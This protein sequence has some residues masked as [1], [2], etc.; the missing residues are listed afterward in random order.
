MHD[1]SAVVDPGAFPWT[2]GQWT[3]RAFAD[4]VI[5]ECHVGT[6]TPDG[7][8]DS[9]ISRLAE[10]RDLGITAVELMPVASFPGR[11]NWGY[12]G[13]SLFAPAEV[14]GGPDSLR[15]FVDASHRLGLAVVLDVVFN[16]F[17]PD[18]NYTGLYSDEYV[19][20]RYHTPWGPAVNFD[21]PG[22]MA[23]RAFF[24]ENLLHW[25]HEYHLDGFRLDA[26]HAIFDA[27]PVHILAELAEAVRDAGRPAPPY[28]IAESHENDVRYVHPLSVGHGFD[29]VWADDFHHAMR[30]L[31]VDEHDG[32]LRGFDG[33]MEALAT[34]IRN[35]FLY[36]GQHDIG[37]GAPRGTPAR[38]VP[39][40]SFVYCIQN[41]D[42]V[43][44]R[45]FGQR[46]NITAAHADFVAATL[47]LLTLPAIPL[48][49]EGQEFA[50]TTPFLYFTD[51]H[52][53]LGRAVSEGRKREFS[54]FHGFTNPLAR[55]AIPDPQA[56]T[57]YSRSVL[58]HDEASYG[59]GLLARQLVKAALH[60]RAQDSV[61]RAY[62][63]QRLPLTTEVT[64]SCVVVAFAAQGSRRW[65]AFNTGDALDVRLDGAAAP[66]IVL[67]SN[68]G[69]FGGND[70]APTLRG[71]TLSIPAHS[72]VFVA[73]D[74]GQPA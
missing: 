14:Y 71:A 73:E 42:Q 9:A 26:T 6:F 17:G 20:E 19:T 25:L 53:D 64:G 32:Y 27:S 10:L 49:F 66:S 39:W 1:L 36:E 8:F 3:P 29:A 61:L 43:G 58:D 15:R 55:E 47:L 22:S 12:D 35:G 63:Q 24:R 11:W 28:M 16:H 45:P 40:T 31:L 37:F 67:S 52:G 18:G 23:T 21:G 69:R 7:T 59:L 50:A 70:V 38:D 30:A 62:R 4:L 48:L 65:L 5:Y 68:D 44:N 60:I 51:H 33:S 13:A 34:A 72:A 46:L 74:R 54:S 41:H 56:E 2:D 57:S